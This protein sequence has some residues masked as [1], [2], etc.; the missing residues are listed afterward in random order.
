VASNCS[1]LQTFNTK[2]RKGILTLRSH[3]RVDPSQAVQHVPNRLRAYIL[4]D[5]KSESPAIAPSGV[6][7]DIFVDF[8]MCFKY[9]RGSLARK[10][11]LEMKVMCGVTY[12]IA[13]DTLTRFSHSNSV[14]M[15]RN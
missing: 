8:M 1:R 14:H 6:R 5:K 3:K 11:E 15:L 7:Q 4:A 12:D 2:V 13:V 10:Y 9:S